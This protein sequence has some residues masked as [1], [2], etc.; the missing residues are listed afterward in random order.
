V[1]CRGFLISVF[2]PRLASQKIEP[3][4]Y[5]NNSGQR[6]KLATRPYDGPKGQ[7]WF[8]AQLVGQPIEQNQLC[9]FGARDAKPRGNRLAVTRSSSGKLEQVN[10]YLTALSGLANRGKVHRGKV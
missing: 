6:R 4:K 8:M 3:A 10:E 9:R 1:L 7:R 2:S 5:G